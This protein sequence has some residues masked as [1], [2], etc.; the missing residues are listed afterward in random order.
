MRNNTIMEKLDELK[1][2]MSELKY[3]FKSMKAEIPNKPVVEKRNIGYE[4]L[5]FCNR[6]P[7]IEKTI[8]EMYQQLMTNDQAV[9]MVYDCINEEGLDVSDIDYVKE[10]YKS[11]GYNVSIEDVYGSSTICYVIMTVKVK[12]Y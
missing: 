8:R 5:D 2:S 9:L 7:T 12:R 11:R 3:E 6:Q 4:F 1:E 10:Y